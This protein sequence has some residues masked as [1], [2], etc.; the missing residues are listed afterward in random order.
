MNANKNNMKFKP[1]NW[2]QARKE[3]TEDNFY[4]SR[5]YYMLEREKKYSDWLKNK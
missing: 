2:S 4:L 1:V 3:I 5:E